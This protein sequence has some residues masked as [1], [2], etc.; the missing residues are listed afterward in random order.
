MIAQPPPVLP[1]E[2]AAFLREIGIT[3]PPGRAEPIA[4]G[5]SSDIWMVELG[6]RRICIKRALPALKVAA[7]WRAPIERSRYE[8]AWFECVATLLPHAVPPLV[9]RSA[10]GRMFAMDFLVPEDHRLWKALLLAGEVDPGF[11]G[12]VGTALVAIHAGSAGNPQVAAEFASDA[13]FHA[14]RLEPYLVATAAKHPDLADRLAAIERVTAETR[15]ALVHGDVSPKNIL[16]GPDGPVFLD[17]ECAWYGD[18]AFDVGFCLNHLMLKCLPVPQRIDALAASFETFVAR[19]L[20]GVSWEAPEALER[21]AAAL[22]PALFLARIDGK[23]PVEYVV[24]E[25]DRALVRAVAR[26]LIA[27]PVAELR[28]IMRR[29]TRAVGTR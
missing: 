21:R 26:E 6:R 5:V 9:G 27:E 20:A 17:A 22:L 2:M 8:F 16:A 12:S 15:L 24:D 28:E 29:W 23:S 18:P 1:S 13:I 10:D 7:D 3:E 11:A 25:G 4:G 14:L 19:Y